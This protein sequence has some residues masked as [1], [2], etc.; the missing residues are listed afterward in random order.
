MKE[1]EREVGKDAFDYGFLIG[2]EDLINDLKA[3]ILITFPHRSIQEFFG[4][5][6][7][8]LQL[9]EGKDTD[10]ILDDSRTDQIFMSNPLFMHFIFWFLSK[11]CSRDYF[12]LDNTDEICAILH[13]FIYSRIHR[14]FGSRQLLKKISCH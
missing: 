9:V 13:S 5:F 4:A 11:R 2:N 8:V 12:Y 6:F 3:D 14:M 1:V 7:F 10:S